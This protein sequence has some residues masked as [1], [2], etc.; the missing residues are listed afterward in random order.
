MQCFRKRFIQE[1][2]LCLTELVLSMETVA[3]DE[4]GG[5]LCG[6]LLDVD[7]AVVT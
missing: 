3:E 2:P 4:D 1:G 7:G 5:A 6:G